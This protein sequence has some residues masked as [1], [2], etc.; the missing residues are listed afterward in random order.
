MSRL[1][2]AL[3]LLGLLAGC[4]TPSSS[5]PPM[6]LSVD[7][8]GP[9]ALEASAEALMAGGYVVRH[10]DASLGRLEAVFSRWPGY[11]VRVEVEGE[12]DHSRLRLAASRGGRTLPPNTLEALAAEILARVG[13]PSP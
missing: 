2:G 13:P 8:P 6:E 4:A 7:A 11:R 1:L 12:G 5:L 9:R 3:L 10:A